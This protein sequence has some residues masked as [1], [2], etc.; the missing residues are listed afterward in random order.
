MARNLARRVAM[1]KNLRDQLEWFRGS[2]PLREHATAPLMPFISARSFARALDLKDEH[3]WQTYSASG[4][5]PESLPS[6]PQLIL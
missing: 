6:L 1:R 3:E 4:L 2:S 5:K